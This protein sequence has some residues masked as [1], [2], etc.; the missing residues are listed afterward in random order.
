MSLNIKHN[1]ILKNHCTFKIGGP[2]DNFV[3]VE[4]E[5]ELKEA[6][7]MPRA[8]LLGNGSNVLFSDKG[9][10][11]TIVKLG[12]SFSKIEVVGESI[13][14]GGSALLSHVS[15]IALEN[16]LSGLEFACG[17][18]ASVGGALLMN[19][20]AYEH[21]V[22]ELLDNKEGFGY[23]KSPY[24]DN[25]EIVTSVKFNL[26]K[27][28]KDAIE[29]RMK[30][31]T[32]RRVTKQPL[33]FP[34]AGS[35]FKR[36]DGYFAGKLIEDAGLKGYQVGGAQ[37]SSLHA[38]FVINTGAATSED[39]INLMHHTQ[40]IVMDKFGVELVPEVIIVEE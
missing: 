1:E 12:E 19:A 33:S 26:K 28:S 38:G 35:F 13:I 14:A 10:R 3:V 32:Q 24:M 29:A 15:K 9:Y 36:P 21:S 16:G 27:D 34:S 30:D 17:I 4:N 5:A 39:V 8:F 20:G 40:K 31:Y 25:G 23:R 2:A 22:S 37:I 18:P 11:G 6:M 7:A